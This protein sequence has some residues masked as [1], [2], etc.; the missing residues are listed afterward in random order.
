MSRIFVTRKIP[1]IGIDA[2]RTAG[3]EVDVFAF[4]RTI[5]KAELLDALSQKQ[6][7]GLLPLLTDTIDEEIFTRAPS[8]KV[9]SNYAVGFN[10]INLDAARHH[11]VVV[12]NTPAAELFSAVAEFTIT[13]ILSLAHRLVE[14]DAL[15]RSGEWKGWGPELLLGQ[16]VYG[17]KLGI[18]GAGHIGAQVASMAKNGLGMEVIYYDIRRDSDLESHGVEF[19]PTLEDLLLTSDVVS[20]HVPLLPLTHYLINKERLALMKKSAYLIN[21]SRGPIID[22]KALAA[23]LAAGEIAG[24][25]L[26]VFEA[27]PTITSELLPMRNVILTP[28]VASATFEARGDMAKLAAENLIDFFK[29]VPVR[30]RV[31]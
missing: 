24:A 30:N 4:D 14:S 22:E 26:D 23:A 10:N 15:V 9:V 13:L 18:V 21:T 3:H 17:K 12:A 8:I 25:A 6:Y 5:T 28:H 29:G 20:L 27:E 2:L 11:G 7:D 16:K 19:V 1:S 31:A